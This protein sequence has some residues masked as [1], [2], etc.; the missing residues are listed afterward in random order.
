MDNQKKEMA[1]KLFNSFDRFSK[2]N[3]NQ[4][5]IPELKRSEVF[6]LFSIKRAIDEKNSKIKVSDISKMLDV[7]PPTV[8]QLITGLEKNGYVERKLNREDRRAVIIELTEKGDEAINKAFNEFFKYFQGL[9][10]CLGCDKSNEL[11][12]L[13]NMVFNYFNNLNTDNGEGKI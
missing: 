12:E 2:L 3:W 10:E 1:Q 4:S 6:T 5:P 8:T 9:V 13:L 11:A 7:A